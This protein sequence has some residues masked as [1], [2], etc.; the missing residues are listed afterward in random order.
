M[1]DAFRSQPGSKASRHKNISSAERKGKRHELET[2]RQPQ[3]QQ[4]QQLLFQSR[5][6]AYFTT[7]APERTVRTTRTISLS[8]QAHTLPTEM[9]YALRS[10]V[11]T[12][13]KQNIRLLTSTHSRALLVSLSRFR[14]HVSLVPL[15]G[16]SLA[17]ADQFVFK[18]EKA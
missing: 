14:R 12:L 17:S 13:V 4:Q 6:W 10:L 18:R 3:Q 2:T 16:Q 15:A 7:T 8:Q 11:G 9:A 5:R 1:C